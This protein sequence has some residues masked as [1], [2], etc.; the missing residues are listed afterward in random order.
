MRLYTRLSVSV[1][2]SADD[3]VVWF[4]CLKTCPDG[5][6]SRLTARSIVFFVAVGR[7]RGNL[8]S[9]PPDLCAK[10]LTHT[11]THTTADDGYERWCM[12]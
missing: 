9:P 6:C 12:G 4:W 5:G 3:K 1:F 2:L 7:A 11:A 8:H 10:S